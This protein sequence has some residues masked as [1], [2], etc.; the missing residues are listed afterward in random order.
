MNVSTAFRS[1]VLVGWVIYAPCLRAQP[2]GGRP[3]GAIPA[4]GKVYGRLIDAQTRKPAEFATV[5][6]YLTFKDS[7]VG[8]GIARSNGDFVVDRLPLGKLR[9]V[10]SHIGYVPLQLEALL[11]R[12]RMEQDLGNMVLQPSEKLLN[13]VQ[14]VGE[15][16]AM[17]MHVDRRVFNVDKDLSTQGG[18][19]VDVMK[20]VPGLSVDVDGNVQMRGSNPQV[21]I[22]GR[23]SAMSLDQLPAEEIDRVEVIT[24]P[25]VAFDASSTGGIINVVLKKSTKPGYSG[26]V[27]A[28]LG[29][30]DRY[31]AGVNLNMREGR[32]GFNLSYNY[33]TG[34]NVTDGRTIRED[35]L[36]GSTLEVFEQNTNSWNRSLMHGGRIGGDVQLSNR[37]TLSFTQSFRARGSDGEDEQQ[38]VIGSDGGEVVG[39]GAQLNSSTSNNASYTTQLAFRRKAPKEGKELT[40]DGTY[41]Y[42][43]RKS[44]SVFDQY[45][46]GAGTPGGSLR[47][48]DNEGGAHMS[49]LTI[50]ADVIDPLNERNKLEWG[51]KGSYKQD[52]TWLYVFMR[53]PNTAEPL[54]DTALSND[55]DIID[56]IN[57]AY[58]NWSHRINDRWS[59]QGGTRFE[60]TWFETRLRGKDQVF[61]YKYPDGGD[62]LLKAL[63]PAVYLS[64]KWEGSLR[65]VQ[66]NF[67]R[68]IERP[69]FWQIMPF[70]MYSDSRNLRIGNP[71]LAPEFSNIAEVNHLLPFLKGKGSWLSSVYGRFTE[72]VITGY[73]AP[74]STDSTL[75]L[76]TFVNG[77]YSTSGGW[78]N[79][80]KVEPIARLQLTLSGN[81]RYTNIALASDEGGLRNEGVNWDAK[82]L[83]AYRFGT[84]GN[85]NV[86]MNGEYE[87]PRIQPQGVTL[88]QYG[89]DASVAHDI[90]KR[91]QAVISVN[92]MFFTRQWGNVLDTP[93]LYQ[94]NFRRREM[95]FVRFTLTW[96]FG[97]QN[98]SLFRKRGERPRNEPGSG[99]GDVEM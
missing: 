97:E 9:V 81:I 26:Q 68:K 25:S 67:S 75:L 16:S 28:G 79:V 40:V 99:G 90:T 61:S 15:R 43:E 5:A 6:V 52:H 46:F 94:E 76:N 56:I 30:N 7:L 22:D 38:Y 39:Y 24:N 82:L 4:I 66:V 33:N 37:N 70:I 23:P 31:Q 11:T 86:Q 53:T 71:T 64:R 88:A 59:L 58:V 35:L 19:G 77:S 29:T 41:N 80:I 34:N 85:W 27:Q 51:L 2:P 62:D 47:A 57:A 72:D 83:A 73:S 44:N 63:F 89:V 17:V 18:T 8:G 69:R 95:R 12:E 36:N 92:D 65:E 1:L 54:R 32:W 49:Q 50:Q 87:S 84:K 93:T 74:L 96:K 48:Q 20:N 14:V 10:I 91:I 55:Y 3:G 60:Q 13:E 45:A 42:W 98:T 21:L 78:E